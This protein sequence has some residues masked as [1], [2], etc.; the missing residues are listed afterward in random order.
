V[1]SAAVSEAALFPCG[2]EYGLR[3]SARSVVSDASSKRVVLLPPVD[4]YGPALDSFEFLIVDN[5]APTTRN[6]ATSTS[7]APATVQVDVDHVPQRPR[8]LASDN[9]ARSLNQRRS[10]LHNIELRAYCADYPD[11]PEALLYSLLTVPPRGKLYASPSGPT[12]PLDPAWRDVTA[13]LRPE[14]IA[15]LGLVLIEAN[16]T[17][18]PLPFPLPSRWL[19]FDSS[20]EGAVPPPYGSLRFRVAHPLYPRNLTATG[21]VNIDLDCAAP[22]EGA[23]SST[24][25]GSTDSGLVANVWMSALLS[26]AEIA[27]RGLSN[28]L[29]LPCPPGASCSFSGMYL[30]VSM[31]GWWRLP[32]SDAKGQPRYVEC[33]PREACV[34]ASF[35][36]SD[37]S[38]APRAG[39]QNL[40]VT[41][42]DMSEEASTASDAENPW[43]SSTLLV[44]DRACAPSYDGYVCASCAPSHYR[45]GDECLVCSGEQQLWFLLLVYGL[46][47]CAALALA[48]ALLSKLQVDTTFLSIGVSFFQTIGSFKKY[49]LDWPSSGDSTFSITSFLHIDVSL[50]SLECTAPEMK[51][52]QQWVLY[53]AIPLI[54]G[55]L[56][57]LGA[58]GLT[59][60]KVARDVLAKRRTLAAREGRRAAAVAD[61]A[62]RPGGKDDRPDHPP[63]SNPKARMRELVQLV[64][65]A[66]DEHPSDEHDTGPAAQVMRRASLRVLASVGVLHELAGDGGVKRNGSPSVNIAALAASAAATKK[67][68]VD[69]KA[70]AKAL[71]LA[72]ASAA[73]AAAANATRASFSWWAFLR[74][75]SEYH[76]RHSRRSMLA[77]YVMLCNFAFLPL[78]IKALELLQCST[79]SDGSSFL[80]AEPSFSCDETRWRTWSSVAW[81]LLFTYSVGL[82]LMY[83][84]IFFKLRPR[85]N[86]LPLFRFNPSGHFAWLELWFPRSMSWMHARWARE[87]RLRRRDSVAQDDP[88]EV[89]RVAKA[90]SFYNGTYRA[91]LQNYHSSYY[92]FALVQVTRLLALSIIAVQM[93]EVPLYQAALA[94]LVLALSLGL[95]HEWRPFRPMTEHRVKLKPLPAK[96][97]ATATVTPATAISA[98]SPA[99][100]ADPILPPEKGKAKPSSAGKRV[101][102]RSHSYLNELNT[103]SLVASLLIL[104]L[105]VVFFLDAQHIQWR[106]PQG[107]THGGFVSRSYPYMLRLL[108]VL[109][110][111]VVAVTGVA[112]VA[113]FWKQL[114]EKYPDSR[115]LSCGGRFGVKKAKFKARVRRTRYGVGD[116]NQASNTAAF[117]DVDTRAATSV[118]DGGTGSEMDDGP[119]DHSQDEREDSSSQMSDFSQ[120][121]SHRDWSRSSAITTGTAT[122]ARGTRMA[123]AAA[124]LKNRMLHKGTVPNALL[125]PSGI[126][127]TWKSGGSPGG[128]GAQLLSPSH[129]PHAAHLVPNH[130]ASPSGVSPS[131]TAG[132][133]DVGVAMTPLQVHHRLQGGLSAAESKEQ[134]EDGAQLPS[135]MQSPSVHTQPR[136]LSTA[137]SREGSTTSAYRREWN[138]V[139]QHSSV[140]RDI[141]P[142]PMGNFVMPRIDR[143]QFGV[144]FK[145]PLCQYDLIA[146]LKHVVPTSPPPPAPA[147]SRRRRLG[148]VRVSSDEDD[149]SDGALEPQLPLRAPD[150]DE[151]VD[152]PT[153]PT[154]AAMGTGTGPGTSTNMSAAQRFIAMR[155]QRRMAKLHANNLALSPIPASPMIPA[156]HLASGASSVAPTPQQQPLS[157]VVDSPTNSNFLQGPALHFKLPTPVLDTKQFPQ[158]D[159][160]ARPPTAHRLRRGVSRTTSADRHRRVYSQSGSR[161]T[162][163]FAEARPAVLRWAARQSD[164]DEEETGEEET[165]EEGDL[166]EQPLAVVGGQAVLGVQRL[167]HSD[168]EQDAQQER[169][170][171][172]VMHTRQDTGDEEREGELPLVFAQGSPPASSSIATTVPVS[173]LSTTRQSV[174]ASL[175]DSHSATPGS[176]HVPPRPSL[177][178][179]SLGQSLDDAEDKAAIH[180]ARATSNGRVLRSG[181]DGEASSSATPR[182]PT[183]SALGTPNMHPASPSIEAEHALNKLLSASPP[184]DLISQNG[185][186]STARLSALR[187]QTPTAVASAAPKSAPVQVSPLSVPW[188]PHSQSASDSKPSLLPGTHGQLMR[189][190]LLA[191]ER[192]PQN[193]DGVPA[194]PI[195]H[196]D[197]VGP[198]VSGA[199]LA[200]PAADILAPAPFRHGSQSGRASLDKSRMEP[201]ILTG[202]KGKRLTFPASAGAT[203][204]RVPSPSFGPANGRGMTSAAFVA[205]EAA[206]F[207]SSSQLLSPSRGGGSEVVYVRGSGGDMRAVSVITVVDSPASLSRAPSVSSTPLANAAANGGAPPHSSSNRRATFG[208]RATAAIA[209][210]VA[211]GSPTNASASGGAAQQDTSPSNHAQPAPSHLLARAASSGAALQHPQPRTGWRSPPPTTTVAFGAS[212]NASSTAAAGFVTSSAAP[213]RREAAEGSRAM[214]RTT[215]SGPVSKQVSRSPS[216]LMRHRR[217]LTDSRPATAAA[218]IAAGNRGLPSRSPSPSL[219][220][221]RRRVSKTPSRQPTPL[222]E[223]MVNDAFERASESVQQRRR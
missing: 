115:M 160:A 202:N 155:Q 51:Y 196:A 211:F 214:P 37:S 190:D 60:A 22:P 193:S 173:A 9:P 218:V 39:G 61:E 119:A 200:L 35:W 98:A 148:P 102:L 1:P 170:P 215:A 49:R 8:V 17:R 183:G 88:E 137:V 32:G 74:R 89:V 50:L 166:A 67:Q 21:V 139:R 126:V 191:P 36:A 92:Y 75:S 45:M 23:A 54:V 206:A 41:P 111:A 124:A 78:T 201:F 11:E 93:Q 180:F 181:I 144:P 120:T 151:A 108:H 13:P 112:M 12:A 177:V 103:L 56:L 25:A 216:P 185:R 175:A 168:E 4:R 19:Y 123:A 109:W 223:Q 220:E 46:P 113:L 5:G 174:S 44:S 10:V 34:A 62:A 164:E 127:D 80:V 129:S 85:H 99:P 53:M 194:T 30:P 114:Q 141:S 43:G 63:G 182:A 176:L 145:A 2:L 3:L 156:G 42:P 40:A 213:T 7:S 106:S 28:P 55:L 71:Q 84:L 221:S 188:Q 15:A 205:A 64:S 157:I 158:Y 58:L 101:T 29:C 132:G 149:G 86:A 222:V 122:R 162:S 96:P 142:G 195:L 171:R 172:I 116:S 100:V 186:R 107:A 138:I 70:L 197:A 140:L 209:G 133:V 48:V 167:E 24:G 47:L 152:D 203:P 219:S 208:R 146:G 217:S 68:S 110:Q 184:T 65:Q 134:Q 128:D 73:A 117:V 136:M 90:M 179:L 207:A 33:T 130:L 159:E 121:S 104:F 154:A 118:E 77:A 189:P 198:D 143:R 6:A 163:P 87:V 52:L 20:N 14:E 79:R 147:D 72:R 212:I 165:E 135:P 66:H 82:W 97:A 210:A 187:V 91:L 105:G 83:F 94:M 199:L 178:A 38:A 18:T 76:F 81:L 131:V 125:S 161:Q 192:S 150:F 31:E 69:P 95:Q 16:S 26:P 204:M 59:G 169:M 27:A 153:A 57:V